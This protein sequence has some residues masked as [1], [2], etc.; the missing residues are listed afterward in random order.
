MTRSNALTPK[1]TSPEEALRLLDQA[2]MYHVP[3]PTVVTA[4]TV[5]PSAAFAEYFAA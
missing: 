1:P 5:D 2:W 4:R 3:L